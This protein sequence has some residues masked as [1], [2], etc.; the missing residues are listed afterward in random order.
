VEEWEDGSLG[1]HSTTC[2][3]EVTNA[4]SNTDNHEYPS[5]KN[6]GRG[7]CNETKLKYAPKHLKADHPG[8]HFLANLGSDSS[9][10]LD[11]S[12]VDH[13]VSP[14]AAQDSTTLQRSNYQLVRADYRIFAAAEEPF[15]QGFCILGAI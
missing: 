11:F 12:K 13:A 3:I 8:R 6:A 1:M 2:N 7:S 4:I 9:V 14:P 15:V 10:I 5:Q